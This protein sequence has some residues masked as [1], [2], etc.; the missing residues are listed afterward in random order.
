VAGRNFWELSEL[1]ETYRHALANFAVPFLS[2]TRPANWTFL[3]GFVGLILSLYCCWPVK[4]PPK[5]AEKQGTLGRCLPPAA[6]SAWRWAGPN[7]SK[8]EASS[9][10]TVGPSPSPRQQQG[11]HHR[12]RRS[13]HGRRRRTGSCV[14]RH[15]RAAVGI[16]V[17]EKA[18]ANHEDATPP[19]ISNLKCILACFCF[20]TRAYH[21]EQQTPTRTSGH[22]P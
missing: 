12:R 4:G 11:Q 15:A 13:R 18:K 10:G 2:G 16:F 19:S 22:T 21:M 6:R 14:Q 17:T 1:L 8:A 5:W 3:L 20:H 9:N 7:N